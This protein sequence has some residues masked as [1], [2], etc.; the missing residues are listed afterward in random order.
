MN[1]VCPKC[2]GKLF[3]DENGNARCDQK[4]T[5]DRARAG[6]YNLMLSAGGGTHG[7]NTDMV[8]ARRKFLDTGAYLPL[9]QR[10]AEII[11]QAALDFGSAALLDIGCGEG[12]YT[13]IIERALG[14]A[15]VSHTVSG[16]DISRDAV[17]RAARRN[18]NF[19]LAV[20]SAYHMPTADAGF[21]IAVNM[22]SPLVPTEVL[23]SLKEGGIFV[24]AIPAEEHLFSLK[25]LLYRTPYKNEV[26]DPAIEGFTLVKTERLSYL[27]ELADSETVS[28]LF[29][30]TPYAYRT[31]PEDAE[32]IKMLTSLKC[33]ADFVIFVYKKT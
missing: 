31:R 13:D 1:F 5:Y 12:Y 19:E 18:K 14:D 8:E 16:F 28:A 2:G 23:R 10:I 17:K 4:H 33:E 22:F 26:A 29:M 21:D 7:D 27:M 3:T 24:M 6:Y 32:C 15:G 20:A 25:K 11:T 30:M 9:A